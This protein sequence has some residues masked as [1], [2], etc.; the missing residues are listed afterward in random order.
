M[1]TL[2]KTQQDNQR[3]TSRG[4][5]P[6]PPAVPRTVS[7]FLKGTVGA[8]WWTATLPSVDR[9]RALGDKPPGPRA[10]CVLLLGH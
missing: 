1:L 5:A 8:Y 3:Q 6:R 4:M 7:E 10:S 2:V 9:G